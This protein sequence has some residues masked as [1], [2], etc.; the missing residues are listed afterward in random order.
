[1]FLLRNL[2]NTSQF[3][4]IVIIEFGSKLGLY[5][6]WVGTPLTGLSANGKRICL[7]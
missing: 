1:M 2:L 3:S 6:A 4:R 5:L 7:I